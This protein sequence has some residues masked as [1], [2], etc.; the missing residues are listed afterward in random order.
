MFGNIGCF[1]SDDKAVEPTPVRKDQGVDKGSTVH[2]MAVNQKLT[3]KLESEE[4][5][6]YFPNHSPLPSKYLFHKDTPQPAPPCPNT[7]NH[8]SLSFGKIEGFTNHLRHIYE[9]ISVCISLDFPAGYLCLTLV[10]GVIKVIF[11]R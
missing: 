3:P 11:S 8:I 10:L 1:T 2:R 9:Y 4:V 7:I 5:E 6:R